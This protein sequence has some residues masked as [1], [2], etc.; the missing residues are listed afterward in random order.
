L[1]L[2]TRVGNVLG[3]LELESL[4]PQYKQEGTDWF[5]VY[6]PAV[7]RELEIEL[8]H[9]FTHQSVVCCVRFSLDGR[10]VAT[11]C[12]RLA[13]IYDV[14]TGQTVATLQDN[15]NKDDTDLYI[16]SVCFSPD[17]KYLAT[18]AE[19]KII[20]V[21]DIASSRIVN[22]FTGHEQDIY[23]LDYSRNG[24]LI[25]SGSGDHTVRLWDL[26]SGRQLSSFQIDDGVTTVAISPNNQ[27]LA[28]G[29][30]DKSVRVWDING[31]LIERLEGD[32]GHR[33][34][35]YSVAFSPDTSSLV[36][37]SLDKTI[38]MW[39]LRDVNGRPGMRNMGQARC[40]RTFEGHKVCLIYKFR[41][42]TNKNRTLSSASHSRPT[43]AG[44]SP[45]PK[46]VVFNFG[47]QTTEMHS[48]C[49]KVTRTVSF[50]WHLLLLEISLLLE[51]E[52]C[53]PESGGMY[54]LSMYS[55]C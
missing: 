17:G 51:A 55:G 28:A 37:G 18:G 2:T 46:I 52:T 31:N 38:K 44:F 27:F 1:P 20:R 53:A 41:S 49:Y 22:S 10:Y 50:L 42:N 48:S 21:W 25:A 30:L 19:D 15:G 13:Q 39:D 9:T 24:R 54:T 6:N 14:V 33:D 26:E 4:P 40:S 5:V 36:S 29:S 45:D 7:R 11:G 34:S 35:V 47:T 8:V 16:R 23:S 12:N 3:D 32:Y 43:T